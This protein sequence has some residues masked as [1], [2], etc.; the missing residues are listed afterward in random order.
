[1]GG[2][3]EHKKV[4]PLWKTIW[5]FLKKLSAELHMIQQFYFLGIYPRE[6]KPWTG[7]DVCTPVF[8]AGLFLQPK[9]GSDPCVYGWMNGE[10]S[11]AYTC[12]R[13]LF[14]LRKEG[15]PDTRCNMMSL[16]DMLSVISQ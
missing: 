3:W 8:I 15:N 5:W 10:T 1:M 16:G 9:G 11:E 4:Q 14:S 6:L 13:L 7:R 2:C 12:N